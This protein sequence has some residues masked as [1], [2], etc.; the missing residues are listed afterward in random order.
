MM[1]AELERQ[2]ARISHEGSDHVEAQLRMRLE[3]LIPREC[4]RAEYGHCLA[5]K[6]CRGLRRIVSH[7]S[8]LADRF[9]RQ[10]HE[11]RHFP[12]LTPQIIRLEIL[13][14]NTVFPTV[15]D[16]ADDPFSKSRKK[17]DGFFSSV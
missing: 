16:V 13:E 17:L 11:M 1:I 12:R 9:S 15:I 14:G 6:R 4:A 8:R 3:D 10:V 5:E 7:Q 2:H